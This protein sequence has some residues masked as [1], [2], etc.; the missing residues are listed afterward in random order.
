MFSKPLALQL[1]SSPSQPQSQR[2]IMKHQETPFYKPR[3]SANWNLDIA[4]EVGGL[5]TSPKSQSWAGCR[6]SRTGA[7]S[8]SGVVPL[9]ADG[10]SQTLTLCPH[11]QGHGRTTSFSPKGGWVPQLPTKLSRGLPSTACSCHQ[12]NP[13]HSSTMWPALLLGTSP[14]SPF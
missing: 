11:T 6:P 8:G 2:Q 5:G 9:E 10:G 14:G 4:R 3:S 12:P 7:L 1:P 13:I